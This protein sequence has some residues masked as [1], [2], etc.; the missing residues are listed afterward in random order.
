MEHCMATC[1]LSRRVAVVCLVGVAC[2]AVG[3]CRSQKKSL[4]REQSG[5]KKLAIVYGR[6]LSQHRGRP[7][8]NEAEFEKYVASLPPAERT[9]FGIGDSERMFISE[10]DGK[11]YVIMYGEPKGPPGPGG[12]PVIAYE[13]EG[14]A[15]KRW[16]ASAL[17]A[18]KEVD[19]ARFRQ[20]VP[21]AKP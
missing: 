6:F 17:G 20:L 11:P 19:E 21:T 3:G 16:V 2:M 8:A 5:L 15:G 1:N 18:V 7:P 4:A 14:K 12:A 13:Q 10:R 9:S